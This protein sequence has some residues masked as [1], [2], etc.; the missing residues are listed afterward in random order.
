L[1][2]LNA[3]SRELAITQ[4]LQKRQSRY[5]MASA[6]RTR[7]FRTTLAPAF[8]AVFPPET[9]RK[10]VWTPQDQTAQISYE[11]D[12]GGRADPVPF[13]PLENGTC[14]QGRRLRLDIRPR[15]CARM[16]LR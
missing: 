2:S 4:S 7:L 13:P 9:D 14:P 3:R 16:K 12:N 8:P 1:F 15:E 5:G 6:A 11:R 10:N